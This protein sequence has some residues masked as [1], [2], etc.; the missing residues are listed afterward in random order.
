MNPLLWLVIV[1]LFSSIS[2]FIFKFIFFTVTIVSTPTGTPVSGS[3]N[4][5]DYPIL[6]S[7]TL[8]CMVDSPPSGTVTY[9]W[10]TTGCYSNDINNTERKCF[11]HGQTTQN[12]ST[13]DVLAKDAGTV[14]CTA[15]TDS[16]SFISEPF[17]FRISG[18]CD[19]I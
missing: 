11:P 2:I 17:T 19:I 3:T 12:V 10:N 16:G 5:F 7:V 14:M 15:T 4:T 18:M 9:S 13:D 1:I 8:A 6:S